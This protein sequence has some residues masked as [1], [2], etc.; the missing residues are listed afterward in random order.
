MRQTTEEQAEAG[1]LF[2]GEYPKWEEE[3]TENDKEE[4]DAR[5]RAFIH[6]RACRRISRAIRDFLYRPRGPLCKKVKMH[7]EQS[8]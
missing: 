6:R 1:V 7:F 8:V 4:P 2:P 5:I 3:C